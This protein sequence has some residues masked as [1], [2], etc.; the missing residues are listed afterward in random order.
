[1]RRSQNRFQQALIGL[2]VMLGIAGTV[3]CGAILTF[4]DR[5][6]AEDGVSDRPTATVF[7]IPTLPPDGASAVPTRVAATPTTEA[8]IVVIPTTTPFVTHIASPTPTATLTR[9]T[10]PTS[11]PVSSCNPKS[12]WVSYRV[13]SGETL[14]EIGLRYD[15]TVDA[16]M[17]AN[18]LSD[19]HIEAGQLLRV[20]PTA[21]RPATATRTSAPTSMPATL[22]N[23]AL[24]TPKPGPTG[25]QS[26]TDGSCTNPDSFISSP[27]VGQTLSGTIQLRGTA[28]IP[29]FAFYKI[30][31]RR[32][33]ASTSQ[34][35]LTLFTGT[36]PV[37][38]GVLASLNTAAYPNAE[39]WLRLVVVD[40]T[41]NY[42][43]RCAILFP[44]SNN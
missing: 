18:C 1:V 38:N 33:G 19:Q 27:A 30:E 34:D 3:L 43:E 14:F 6:R 8:T 37:I 16:M 36:E 40:S 2:V 23:P 15:L 26:T 10:A 29:N 12:G 42:P 4:G 7:H 44:F 32:E 41:G 22:G 24:P 13:Q 39:Y 17:A 21:A 31:I 35:Y 11:P 9:T 25:T 28:N 20:P 5:L